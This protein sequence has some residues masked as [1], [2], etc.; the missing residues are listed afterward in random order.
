[1]NAGVSKSGSPAPRSMTAC[2][3]ARSA[4]ARAETASVADSLSAATFGDKAEPCDM[5][6]GAKG[7]VRAARRP[8]LGGVWWKAPTRSGILGAPRRIDKPDRQY[9]KAAGVA[10]PKIAAPS[11][12]R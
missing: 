11:A 10:A 8:R 9:V 6:D 7:D 1:M 3:A 12:R 4:L 2:P 5:S